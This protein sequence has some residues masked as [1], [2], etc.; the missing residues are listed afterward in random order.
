MSPEA[1]G[2]QARRIGP[3]ITDWTCSSN[4]CWATVRSS[5]SIFGVNATL[6]QRARDPN[7]ANSIPTPAEKPALP[8]KCY[9]ITGNRVTS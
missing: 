6:N 8:G 2:M 5:E 1:G 9:T 4:G 7:S 3:Y